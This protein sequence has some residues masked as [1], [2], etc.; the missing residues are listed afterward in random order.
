MGTLSSGPA[1][2]ASSLAIVRA[3]GAVDQALDAP[4]R[5]GIPLGNW[6]WIVRQRMVTLR[7]V[8]TNQSGT[9]NDGWLAARGGPA[10]QER[11]VLLARVGSMA[12]Q[13]LDTPDVETTRTELKKLLAD[14]RRHLQRVAD[15][16][17]D[18]DEPE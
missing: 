6:R 11:T 14:V 17:E 9:T 3:V 1:S 15:D 8:L 13:V 16:A 5:A 2:A 12:Q 7:E 10:F 4:R 18:D